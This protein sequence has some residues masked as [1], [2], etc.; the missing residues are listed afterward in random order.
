VCQRRAAAPV[1]WGVALAFLCAALSTG[2]AAG[3][4]ELVFDYRF[5]ASGFFSDPS[6]RAR[7]EQAADFFRDFEDALPAIE[8]PAGVDF[9]AR[10]TSPATGAV[11]DVAPLV[12][13][14]DTVVIFVGARPLPALAVGGPS[15]F[16]CNPCTQAFA[17]ALLYRGQ[18]GA[19]LPL[20]TDT[21]LWA[22]SLAFD[23]DTSWHFGATTGT[24]A[25]AQADFLSV[26]VHELAHVFG[27]GVFGSATRKRAWDTYTD[28]GGATW[29]GPF[30]RA[31]F[32][33]PVPLVPL[34]LDHFV[35]DTPGYLGATGPEAALDPSLLP[36]TRKLL[37]PLDLAALRDLGWQ[38]PPSGDLDGDGVEDLAD[39]C[40]AGANGPLR[41]DAGGHVQLDSDGDGYGN[42][43]DPDLDGNGLVNTVDLARFK[44]VFL[45][46]DDD[47]DLNGDG[48]V[49]LADL[50]IL[51]R[52]FLR[53]PGPSALAP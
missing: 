47:A 21:T 15:G 27:V 4:I 35:E 45:T 22:G 14:E 36:G 2:R 3:A 12:V 53:A 19:E 39:D 46:G 37:T 6:R 29:N 34:E 30:A 33:G 49:N 18:P 48:F 17:S 16:R 26:A 24:L 52:F 23:A 40:I 51:R 5:D 25:A 20:P 7:L 50:T 8:A 10:V 41:P 43:C 38:L 28:V 44:G 11:V 1:G 9:A 13:P 42:A 32:G 31:L